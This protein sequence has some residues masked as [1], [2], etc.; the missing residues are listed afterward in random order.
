[1]IQKFS[2]KGSAKEP[3]EV[4]FRLQGVNLSAYCNCPAGKRGLHCKHR[5]GILLGQSK[6]IIG[7]NSDRVSEVAGWVEG[8][9]VEGPLNEFLYLEKEANKI[10][11]QLKSVKR[12][13]AK[14]MND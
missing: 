11:E 8:S 4:V 5:I 3:Y 1:M 13:L 7:D 2:V 6:G 14:A 9:D 12:R 10:N